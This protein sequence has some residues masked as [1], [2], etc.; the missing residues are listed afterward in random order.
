MQRL[1]QTIAPGRRGLGR[2]RTVPTSLKMYLDDHRAG[3]VAGTELAAN[4]CSR[5]RGRPDESFYSQLTNAIYED[6]AAL[7]EVIAK[8]GLKRN[9]GLARMTAG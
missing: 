8:L 5:H 4:L 2:R 6:R 1:D 3:A 7:D 9:S